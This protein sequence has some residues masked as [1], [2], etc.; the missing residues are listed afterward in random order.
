MGKTY[1]NEYKRQYL[2]LRRDDANGIWNDEGSPLSHDVQD[3][4]HGNLY[5]WKRNKTSDQLAI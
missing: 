4:A 1:R 2:V 3:F 5:L